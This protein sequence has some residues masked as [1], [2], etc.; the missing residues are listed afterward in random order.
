MHIGKSESRYEHLVDLG[1]SESS[2]QAGC[3]A[4]C[5]TARLPSTDVAFAIATKSRS[6]ARSDLILL[7]T[8]QNFVLSCRDAFKRELKSLHQIAG[9]QKIGSVRE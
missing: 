2:R 5:H 7:M 6:H 8:N 4:V 1:T 9:T 3:L